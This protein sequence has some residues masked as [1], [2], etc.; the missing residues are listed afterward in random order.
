MRLK[1]HHHL[2]RKEVW[3]DMFTQEMSDKMNVLALKEGRKIKTYLEYCQAFT[4]KDNVSSGEW[5]YNMLAND[6]D[7]VL[8]IEYGLDVWENKDDVDYS[9][10]DDIDLGN[11][12]GNKTEHVKRAILIEFQS[13]HYDEASELITTARKKGQDIGLTVLNAFRK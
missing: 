12:L 3:T 13:E 7:S 10:L 4:I 1:A 5:E 11:T 6:W 8:L 9:V 2:N